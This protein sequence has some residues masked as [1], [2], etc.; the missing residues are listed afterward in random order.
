MKKTVLFTTII[1]SLICFSCDNEPYEGEIF[2]ADPSTGNPTDPGNGD[3]TDPVDPTDPTNPGTTL[4]L[5]DYDYMKSFSS[6]L[7]GETSFTA[8]F[9]INSQNQFTAQ[10]TSITFLGTTVNGVGAVI[11]DQ[12]SDV[13]ELRTT[14]DNIL[15]NRTTVTY[16][17]GKVVEIAFEDLQD[18]VDSFTFSFI[19][20]NNEI[21]RTKEG[22]NFTTKFT[23]DAT[24]SKLLKRE[25]IENG[26]INKTEII[27]YDAAGNLTSAVITGQDANT[28]TYTYDSN[29]NPLRNTL[30]DLY[31]FSILNDEYD[32]QYEHW[33]AVIYSTNNM[34]VTTTS[35]GSSNLDVQYDASSRITSRSG[36][37]FTSVPTISS[38]A[39]ITINE[40]FQYVN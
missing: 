23:F 3:P 19:H 9:V 31:L 18:P 34:T 32:D 40:T 5:A 38:D 2:I 6:P 13:I 16:N 21:T 17:L 10:N 25:T 4:Q 22:T 27:S 29:T 37:I 35:Q 14:V 28:Y 30:N 36:T 7:G 11:R 20:N 1:L 24:T 33:Q 26:T 15:V 12:N 39:T 8:D